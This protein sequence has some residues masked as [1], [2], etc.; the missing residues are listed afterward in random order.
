[1]WKNIVEPGRPQMTIWRM[2]I[3]SWIPKAI[4]KYSEYVIL[5][6]FP[7]TYWIHERA[8][9]VRY[10][11]I[12]CLV[13]NLR[14]EFV[15]RNKTRVLCQI[16]FFPYVHLMAFQQNSVIVT[17]YCSSVI[18]SS[19]F[20]PVTLALQ[21]IGFWRETLNLFYF[22][23]V[24]VSTPK[25]SRTRYTAARSVCE[26]RLPYKS[27]TSYGWPHFY[28]TGKLLWHYTY[29]WPLLLNLAN[30]VFWVNECETN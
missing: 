3:A 17:E 7:R 6:A 28:G 13:L 16:P 1:M 22:P 9:M 20:A 30:C 27:A 21:R 8:S 10:T 14:T 23:L 19:D 25:H 4:T 5:I 29:T 2:R 12:A 11:C 24:A 26:V 18:A 15:G